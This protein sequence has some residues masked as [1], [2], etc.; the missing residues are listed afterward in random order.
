M[1]YINIKYGH[2]L[3]FKNSRVIPAFSKTGSQFHFFLLN[4][5]CK[6]FN[7]LSDRVKAVN[8]DFFQYEAI[9]MQLKKLIGSNSNTCIEHGT[10]I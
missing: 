4:S 9:T 2:I 8:Y 3:K 7:F 5:L 1:V 10:L 6:V